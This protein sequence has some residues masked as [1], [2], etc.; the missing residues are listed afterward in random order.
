[1]IFLISYKQKSP[2][3]SSILIPGCFFYGKSLLSYSSTGTGL[4]IVISYSN[5]GTGLSITIDSAVT[6]QS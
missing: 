5:T 2:G 3:I 4:S 6:R 1:M